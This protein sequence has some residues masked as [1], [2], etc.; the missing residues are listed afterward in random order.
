MD[1]DTSPQNGEQTL[2]LWKLSVCITEKLD[3]TIKD[4]GNESLFSNCCD[5]NSLHCHKLL[6][7][8]CSTEGEYYQRELASIN[9]LLN[10]LF[11]IATTETPNPALLWTLTQEIDRKRFLFQQVHARLESIVIEVPIIAHEDCHLSLTC[12]YNAVLQR[13]GSTLCRDDMAGSPLQAHNP[14][15]KLTRVW[16]SCGQKHHL[17]TVREQDHDLFPYHTTV[18]VAHVMHLIKNNAGCL[19]AQLRATI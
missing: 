14:P 1:S 3:G 10:H 17:H 4:L 13:D 15:S 12:G 5:V 11:K 18:A 9:T 6:L 2:N 16:N 19:Q 7:A 8:L